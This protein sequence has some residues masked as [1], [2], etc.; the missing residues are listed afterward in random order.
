[1][2]MLAPAMSA[3]YG[4]PQ[5]LAWNIGTTGRTRSRSDIANTDP[6]LTAIECRCMDR[7]L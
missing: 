4:R 7:W 3:A 1:M 2:I 5:A 6:V